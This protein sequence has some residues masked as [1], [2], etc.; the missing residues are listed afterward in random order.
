MD[1]KQKITRRDF[2]RD[3]AAVTAGMA[4]GLGAAGAAGAAK[5]EGDRPWT[6][7]RSYNADMEYRRLGKTGLW[8][9]AVCLGGHWK[10]VNKAMTVKGNV[11]AVRLPREA[12]LRESF[13]ANRHEVISR[14]LDVGINFVDACTGD[15][16]IAYGHALKGRREKMYVGYSWYEHE[17]R[18]GKFRTVDTLMQSLEEGLKRASLE[19]VDVWRIVANERGSRH[20]QAEVDE[21]I[22]ALKKAREQGKCRFTGVSSH[23]H[24]WLKMLIETYPDVIQVVLFPYTASSKVLPKDSLFDAAIKHDVGVLGIKP[25]A[26]NSLFKGD[27][28]A[29]S[30]HAAEDDRRARLAIRYILSNPAITAPIPGLISPHQV[31]NVAAAIKEI[32]KLNAAEKAELEKVGKEM[33]A[34]LSDDYQW[35]KQWQYV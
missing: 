28:S 3:G 34:N 24:A 12:K 35:L 15:E 14:C 25:F 23:D 11:G 17:M 9:S 21:M 16:T 1:H 30:P 33:W 7:T 6:K 27:S 26:N 22:G 13:L 4:V 2:M 20:T 5:T 29:D 31:D 18:N 8:V 10:R 19:Y 32:R